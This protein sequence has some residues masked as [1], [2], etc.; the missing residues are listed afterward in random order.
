LAG[1]AGPI[2]GFEVPS[3]QGLLASASDGSLAGAGGQAGF[4]QENVQYAAYSGQAGQIA[5][6]QQGG[7]VYQQAAYSNVSTVEGQQY[8]GQFR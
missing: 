2:G 6:D 4:G 8:A 1:A 5:G 3:G 7:F